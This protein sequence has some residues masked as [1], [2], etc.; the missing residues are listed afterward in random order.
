[1]KTT[2]L[3]TN[4][5]KLQANK[6]A[7]NFTQNKFLTYVKVKDMTN[8]ELEDYIFQRAEAKVLLDSTV[9]IDK[10]LKGAE[11]YVEHCIE[12]FDGVTKETLNKMLKDI[13]G[14]ELVKQL[15]NLGANKL[16]RKEFIK[17]YGNLL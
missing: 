14:K 11:W 7:T 10:A 4:E 15:S 16:A 1:M 2:P 6:S 17:Q 9:S 3:L 8:E 12:E 5:I 13:E